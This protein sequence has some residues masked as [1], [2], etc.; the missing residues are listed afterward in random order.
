MKKSKNIW[1]ILGITGAIVLLITSGKWTNK[2]AMIYFYGD[3]CPHCKDVSAYIDSNDVKSKLS[4]RELETYKNKNNAQ[5]LAAKAKICKINTAQGVPVPFFFDGEKCYIGSDEIIKLFEEKMA[6]N[7][8]ENDASS[9]ETNLDT[10]EVELNKENSD[11]INNDSA[12]TM[13]LE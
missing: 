13:I 2:P 9:N 10:N 7:L 1:I 3:A 12:E 6:I 8:E 4:F 5:L 11:E